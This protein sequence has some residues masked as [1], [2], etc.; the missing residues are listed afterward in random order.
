MILKKLLPFIF[1]LSTA[2]HA[3]KYTPG[4]EGK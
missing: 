1:L 2:I 4:D 3:Q